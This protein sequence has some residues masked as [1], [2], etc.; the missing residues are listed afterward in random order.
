MSLPKTLTIKTKHFIH[1]FNAYHFIEFIHRIPKRLIQLL[2]LLLDIHD[3]MI[4]PYFLPIRPSFLFDL[5]FLSQVDTQPLTN[6][7]ALI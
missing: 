2:K 4:L 6:G 1:Y 5:E 7:L 3:L